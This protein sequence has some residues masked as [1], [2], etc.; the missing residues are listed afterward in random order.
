MENPLT[1]ESGSFIQEA[2]ESQDGSLPAGTSGKWW[3]DSELV[4]R[5]ET[6]EAGG[7]SSLEA[8]SLRTLEPWCTCQSAKL[9]DLELCDLG[10]ERNDAPETGVHF[11]P[12]PEPTRLGP[13]SM[14]EGIFLGS[15]TS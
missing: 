9:E 5:P 12:G 15:L 8:T 6:Q 11:L 4:H 1:K 3:W 7:D 2:E 10:Q 14:S 13:P